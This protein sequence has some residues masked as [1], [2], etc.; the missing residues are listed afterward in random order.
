VYCKRGRTK[1]VSDLLANLSSNKGST[2]RP[3]EEG[4]RMKHSRI[5]NK[6]NGRDATKELLERHDQMG[7]FVM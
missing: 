5:P 3:A 1:T 4:G 7:K 2:V 6:E